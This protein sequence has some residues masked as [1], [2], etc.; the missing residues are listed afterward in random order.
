MLS[1][2]L[3]FVFVCALTIGVYYLVERREQAAEFASIRQ[4]LSGLK[5]KKQDPA[6]GPKL[7]RGADDAQKTLITA[8]VM[9]R[10]RIKERLQARLESA[11]LSWKPARVVQA[12]AGVFLGI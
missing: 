2:V 4:R 1:A 9:E 5:R 3:L 7:I 8:R 10:L 12:A 11:A 6:A